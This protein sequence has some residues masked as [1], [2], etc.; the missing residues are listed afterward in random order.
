MFGSGGDFFRRVGDLEDITPGEEWT[1][2][3]VNPLASSSHLTEPVLRK[4]WCLF[5]FRGA[6]IDQK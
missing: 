3:P 1:V 4:N 6:R 2:L 5:F